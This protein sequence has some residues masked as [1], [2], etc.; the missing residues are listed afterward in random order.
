MPIAASAFSRVNRGRAAAELRGDSTDDRHPDRRHAGG[1]GGCRRAAAGRLVRLRR[2]SRHDRHCRLGAAG[3]RRSAGDAPRPGARLSGRR[4]LLRRLGARARRRR[5]P[6]AARR[7]PVPGRGRGR[8]GRGRREP[9]ARCCRTHCPGAAPLRV[10]FLDVDQA[11]ATLVQFPT[12]QSPAGGRRRV[13]PRPV[14]GGG[15]GCWR[16]CCGAPA[17]AASTTWP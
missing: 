15:A 7:G 11:D 5:A 10:L 3:G 6:C 4:R 13:R 1:G 12:G 16:R 14:R 8:C 17:C 2:P 9:P